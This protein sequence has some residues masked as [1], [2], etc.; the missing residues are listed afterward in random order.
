MGACKYNVNNSD[1]CRGCENELRAEL[2]QLREKANNLAGLVERVGLAPVA[3]YYEQFD[4]KAPLQLL[5][6]A[7]ADVYAA[8]GRK[9]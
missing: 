1:H 5:R 9:Q 2:A 4:N 6:M 7:V 3:G 8:T